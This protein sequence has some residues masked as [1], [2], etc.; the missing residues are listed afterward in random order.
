M[1]EQRSYPR[2]RIV[3]FPVYDE[4]GV[5]LLKGGSPLT[6]R[7]EDL[8]ARREIRMD[9]YAT[10]VLHEGADGS[11]FAIT[12]VPFTIGRGRE[13]QL[14]PAH[15]LVSKKHC[16]LRKRGYRVT[17][18]DLGSTNG[19]FVNGVRVQALVELSDGDA[20][21]LGGEVS[22]GVRIF[23]AVRGEYGAAASGLIVGKPANE[24]FEE[25]ATKVGNEKVRDALVQAG[26]IPKAR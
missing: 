21:S 12:D 14:R 20:I 8:L 2:G 16:V 3:R 6:D 15:T 7:L 19:T 5:L 9:V 1:S 10:L 13:C 11:E 23:A 24:E 26:L 18:A 17:L 4:A 25:G 22:V